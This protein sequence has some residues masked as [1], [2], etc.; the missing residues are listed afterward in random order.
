V[1]IIKEAAMR[2]KLPVPTESSLIIHQED[3]SGAIAV[4]NVHGCD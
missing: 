4:K 2:H 1:S 3:K